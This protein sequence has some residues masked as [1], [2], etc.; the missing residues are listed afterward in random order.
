MSYVRPN[1]VNSRLCMR[2]WGPSPSKIVSDLNL[3]ITLRTTISIA[4]ISQL[5]LGGYLFIQQK[6]EV[7]DAAQ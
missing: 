5:G 4:V 7:R 6:P 2:S 3:D 1:L